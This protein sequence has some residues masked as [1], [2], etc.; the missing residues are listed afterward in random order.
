MLTIDKKKS[1]PAYQQVRQILLHKIKNG[2]IRPG[3]Q[4]PNRG[5]AL[6][7]VRY[8]PHNCPPGRGIPC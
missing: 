6:Q 1:I 8:K 5:P 7:G 2:E 4:L 3:E